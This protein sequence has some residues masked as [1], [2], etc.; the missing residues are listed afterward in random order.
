MQENFA[1]GVRNTAWNL[2]CYTAVFSVVTQRSSPGEERLLEILLTFG[3]Q[4]PSST[5]KDWKPVPVIRNPQPEIQNL[6]LS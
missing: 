1:Y 4:N 3:I 5:D 2:V 6:S